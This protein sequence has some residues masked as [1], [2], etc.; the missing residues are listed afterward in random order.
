MKTARLLLP[1]LIL[2]PAFSYCHTRQSPEERASK[3]DAILSKLHQLDLL[4]HILPLLLTK[5]QLNPILTSIENSR[6]LIKITQES[7]YKRLIPFDDD[8]T[9]ALAK[10]IDGGLVPDRDLMKKAFAAV[11]AMTQNR[12]IITQANISNVTEAVNG[13]LNDGQK[14]IMMVQLD[15]KLFDKTLD[16]DKMSDLEK[17]RF[18]VSNILLDPMAYDVLTKLAASKATPDK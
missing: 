17:V 5:A 16:P 11:A 14:K 12:Q 7:E 3:S 8:C 9:A 13:V 1:L 2:L 10:A 4:N 6:K 15:P 18:Y